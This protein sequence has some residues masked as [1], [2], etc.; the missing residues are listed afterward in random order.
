MLRWLCSSPVLRAVLLLV[1]VGTSGLA[2]GSATTAGARGV[3]EATSLLAVDPAAALNIVDAPGHHFGFN[4]GRVLAQAT[5]S[6]TPGGLGPGCT[7]SSTQFTATLT[8]TQEVP[9][10]GSPA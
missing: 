10:T 8:S 4:Q 5:P 7:A 2:A 1:L 6:L 9:P 3:P